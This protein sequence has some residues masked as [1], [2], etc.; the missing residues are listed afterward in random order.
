MLSFLKSAVSGAAVGLS[1]LLRIGLKPIKGFIDS[2]FRPKVTPVPGSVVYCDLW[3]AADHSGIYVENGQISNIVV[4]GMA[5]SQ[6]RWSDA[7]DFTSKSKLGRKIYVSSSGRH[8]VGDDCVAMGAAKHIGEEA[9]YGLVIKNC[10]QFSSKCVDYSG[11]EVGALDKLWHEMK[12][13][14]SL[15]WEPTIAE[16]K[17]NAEAK[18]GATKWLLWDWNGDAE[19]EPEPDWDEQNDFFKNQALNQDFIDYLRHEL[20]QTQDYQREIADENIPQEILGRLKGFEQ[21][22]EQVSD[23]YEEVKGFLAACPEAQLSYNDIQES[24]ID[25]QDLAR[26]LQNNQKIKDLA[27]KMGRAYLAE[28]VKKRRKVPQASRSEV[29]GTHRS[30]DLVRLLPRELVNLEDEDLETLFYA[31]L[32]EKNLLTYELQGVTFHDEEHEDTQQKRTGPV[33]ACLDTSGS[34]SGEPLKKARAALLA[35]A[36][37]LKREGRSLHVLLFGGSGEVHEFV[38]ESGENI[39]GLLRFLSGG[40]GGGTDF[41]TPLNHALGVIEGQESFVKADILMLSDGDCQ[42]SEAFAQSFKERKSRADCMVYSVLCNG[43]RVEDNFSD[44][45]LTL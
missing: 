11:T 37:I 26:E 7:R 10:H 15:D 31:R 5:Q 32:L 23:K 24:Q 16:L 20:A 17:R 41:E 8:A 3:W 19:N 25:F 43:V 14:A 42:L 18:L 4:T 29:H 9:F 22:L 45:V 44:E 27:H 30:D 12:G 13:F 28:A 35:I 39:A 36:N 2:H 33:V 6:V 40:F 34:M 1:T 21:T 38:M